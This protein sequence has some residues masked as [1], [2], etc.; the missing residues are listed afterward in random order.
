MDSLEIQGTIKIY[1][2]KKERLIGEY[3]NKFLNKGR[4]ALLDL[5]MGKTADV[6]KYDYLTIG[7]GGNAVSL[8]D[9]VLSNE[10]FRKPITDIFQYSDRVVVD[11]FIE[12]TE[13]NFNWLEIGLVTGGT[14]GEINSGTLINRALIDEAKNTG[15]SIT[16]SWEVKLI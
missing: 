5:L 8:D 9:I 1:E 4:K 2:G 13:A 15:K 14:W 16:I 6:I 3:K 11:T 10:R 12:R 7:D